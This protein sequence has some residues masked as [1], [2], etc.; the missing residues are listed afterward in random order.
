MEKSKFYIIAFGVVF[1]VCISVWLG[2]RA[3]QPEVKEQAV[4]KSLEEQ[5]KIAVFKD[6]KV[7]KDTTITEEAVLEFL[8]AQRRNLLS[9][10]TKVRQKAISI[11]LEQQQKNISALTDILY[12][13][14][15]YEES[16][17]IVVDTMRLLGKLRAKE[18]IVPLV[19]HIDFK[20]PGPYFSTGY[21][22][23]GRLAVDALI[24]IGK[25]G[26][27]VVPSVVEVLREENYIKMVCTAAVIEQVEG[28]EM[29]VFYLQK[30]IEKETDS[31]KQ[32][33]L[34]KLKEFIERSPR[35]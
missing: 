20:D 16:P 32:E 2:L 13:D 15:M 18:A 27:S 35:F 33:I 26:K 24:E 6:D 3:N 31:K 28:K 29:G 8:D 12:Y 7:S 10:D 17:E 34:R 30:L 9:K 25:I 5:P 23:Q 4:S 21:P 22:T 19:E 14:T 11:I 1:L